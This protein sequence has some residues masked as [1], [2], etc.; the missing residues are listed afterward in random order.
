MSSKQFSKP[1]PGGARLLAYDLITQVNRGGAYANLR[2][3]E[4][5]DN[6]DLE[7][8]DRAFATE[9][10]Y[11]TLRMQG[12][13]DYAISKNADRPFSELDEKIVD[14]LRLGIH[15]IF[16]MRVPI[17]AAV[18]ETVE[19][20]RAVAGESKASYVNAILRSISTDLEI[21]ERLEKDESI[22]NLEKLAILHSHPTWII[23]AYYDQLK[24]WDAVIELLKVNNVPVAPHII[25]WPGKSTVAE[26]LE[27]G[28]T[29]LALGTFSV[30]SDHLPNEYPA[31]KD[32]RAG[33]QDMGS[34][35]ISETFF[36][37]RTSNAKEW[38][39]LCAGPGG[40]A[41]LLNNL[42]A[43]SDEAYEFLANEPSEH[44]AELVA[45]VVP[46]SKIVSNDG[47]NFE[48][49]G[50]KFDRILIDAPC[51]GLGALRRRP[52]ARWR[53]TLGDLKEL[54]PLQRELIDSAYEML[55]PGGIIAF[56]T[57]SPLLAET[58]G[59]VLDAQYRH[60][61]LMLLDISQFSPAGNVGVNDD[62]TLQLWT[63]IEG[64]DSMFMA[65]LQ[66][67]K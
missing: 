9:L 64:S 40:K 35:L 21:Y 31:I 62:G 13:H 38:L 37:T 18:G 4:L 29:K 3:P 33:I 17:H 41:A 19:V 67:S 48:S 14:L 10:A 12:K 61:D 54:L 46:R 16:E 51:S 5:L 8:R 36:A 25:A 30:L 52:E 50:K 11:G 56:A 32:K 34:Q 42:L 55:N 20:A 66:K 26:I 7:L 63:H 22:S 1:K 28:G 65:L 49:F 43:Q 39:D 24:D 45:R 58:K 2:L 44:R 60:K 59:Q 53:R 27:V 6:S 15:Q 57:C 47:R 23:S